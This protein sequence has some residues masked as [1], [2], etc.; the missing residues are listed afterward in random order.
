LVTLFWIAAVAGLG[1]GGVYG[2]VAMG[3]TLVMA[4]SGV[5]NFIQGTIL[6]GGALVF[7]WLWQL[8]GWPF[9]GVM[10]IVIAGGALLGMFSYL[11]AVRPV[12][13]RQGVT[14]LTE[15]TLV[16]TFGLGLAL[17]SI[18][19]LKFG[20]TTY[21]V[22]TY[23]SNNP[24]FIGG[25]P[26]RPIY[27]VML[28]ATLALVIAMEVLLRRT[29]T[30]LVLRT[31]VQDSEGAR[32][33]GIPVMKVV[34]WAFAGGGILAAVAGAMI[35]PVTQASSNIAGDLALY[36]F[37]GMAIGG[38]GSFK[39]AFVGGLIVGLATTIPA[40]WINPN[41]TTTIVYLLMVTILLI[42]PRGLFGTAG[43]F[44]SARLRTV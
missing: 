41:F 5:F 6:M 40:V 34:L 3:Y 26:I 33:A 27:V 35:V 16:T 42:R 4:A 15:V 24:W 18:V 2:L 21:P 25:V 44:G 17:N 37:A 30:G 31:T 13:N 36:G 43:S 39:G 28:G 8:S 38:Y 29:K 10:A 19:A 23:V 7:Y 12:A 20:Y 14:E 1:L 22:Q 11:A 32:L 9:L